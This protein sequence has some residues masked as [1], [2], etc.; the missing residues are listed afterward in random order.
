MDLHAQT[1][2]VRSS[3]SCLHSLRRD[4][5]AYSR[6]VLPL[7]Q[8]GIQRLVLVEVCRRNINDA[9]NDTSILRGLLVCTPGSDPT[10]SFLCD[11]V[12][13]AIISLRRRLNTAICRPYCLDE[14]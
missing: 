6:D 10:L 12:D 9:A 5:S 8:D 11:Q 13:S 7:D 14:V 4:V 1:Q 2:R 3:L